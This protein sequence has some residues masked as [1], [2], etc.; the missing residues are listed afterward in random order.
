ML[1]LL[2]PGTS[3]Y[4]YRSLSAD[5]PHVMEPDCPA[6]SR[7]WSDLLLW[8]SNRSEYLHGR[9]AWIC[10]ASFRPHPSRFP[11]LEHTS[12]GGPSP[13]GLPASPL[14]QP[15]MGRASSL[16]SVIDRQAQALRA[17]AL[18]APMSQAPMSQAPQ[19]V[20]PLC[21]PLPSSGSRPATP[22]QQA[23]QPP[24]KPKGRV[25]PSTP[26]PINLRPWAVKMQMVMGGKELEAE[27]ITP[28]PPVLPREHVKG[29]PLGQ[30][31]SRCRAR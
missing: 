3:L 21:Q 7:V 13:P 10:G 19:M 12:L 28:G 11:H 20:P 17:M 9:Y 16:R 15:P 31:V 27:M 22:Y 1:P 23:V 18:W 14:Y 30:L 24:S 29:P 8:R 6:G 4:M 2:S 5:S 25:S 26:P